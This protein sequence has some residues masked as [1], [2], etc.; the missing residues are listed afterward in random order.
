MREH[1]RHVS[2]LREHTM[3]ES[4]KSETLAR[5]LAHAEQAGLVAVAAEIE[6]ELLRR[7]SASASGA[8]LDL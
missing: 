6:A 4:V 1:N 8:G 7:E 2:N 5:W 3:Y